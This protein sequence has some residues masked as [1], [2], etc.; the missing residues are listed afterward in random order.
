MK[1]QFLITLLI[2][3]ISFGCISPYIQRLTNEE[4]EDKINKAKNSKLIVLDVYHNRCKTCKYIEPII[5]ELEVKYAENN[6][7]VFLKY[8]L[9]NLFTINDS[10]KI[11]TALGLETIYKSQKYSGIVIFINPKTKEVIKDLIAEYNINEY[12]KIIESNI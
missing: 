2:I 4:I 3:L 9:S 6:N 10:I 7:V 11:A 5:K 1:L 8:D 12:T